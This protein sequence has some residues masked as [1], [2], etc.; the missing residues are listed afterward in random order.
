MDLFWGLEPSSPAGADA[1][2]VALPDPDAPLAERL[3]PRS[4]GD[5]VGQSHLVGPAG[6]L[7]RAIASGHAPSVILCGPPGTGKT[8]I[9]GLLADAAGM[10]LVRL[11]AVFSGTADLRKAFAEASE[12]RKAGRRT[13]LF[14]DEIH[15]YNRTQQDAFLP[16]VEDGTI[17]LIGATTENPSFEINA[18]LL[19]RCRIMMLE[20][21]SAGDLAELVRRAEGAMGRS[22]SITPEAEAALIKASSGDGRYLVNQLETLLSGPTP[23]QPLDED[24]MWAV[25]ERRAMVHDKAGDRH[26]D[27]A[28]ALQKS[29]RGSDPHASLYYLAMM[30]KAGDHAM[31]IRRLTMMATEEVGMADPVALQQCI[32]ARQAFDMLGKPEGEHAIAQACI[33]VATAPKSNASYMA[34]KAAQALIAATNGA[35]PPAR[36]K[37]APTKHMA[38]MG[39]KVGYEYD[40]DLP[41]AF[42]GMD[43]WPDEVGRREIYRPSPRGFEAQIGRRL[44]HW[45]GIREDRSS[46]SSTRRDG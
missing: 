28:S 29:V 26:Y 36:I 17:V 7:T 21:L 39:N 6:R 14:V 16:Y 20:P 8:S 11:S 46:G 31:A 38:D 23:E 40:H 32:A 30:M 41:D 2:G 1:A 27:L 4:L 13:M 9:A 35:G 33:Y 45:D 25:I 37:N 22:A 43:F 12:M 24:G 44:E 15:R 18:A 3:R 19:S 10:R 5:I 42:S 34:L